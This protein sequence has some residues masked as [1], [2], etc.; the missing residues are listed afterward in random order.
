MRVPLNCLIVVTELS[1]IHCFRT[2]FNTESVH[3]F[4]NFIGRLV[5][6]WWLPGRE[7]RDFDKVPF[8]D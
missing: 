3:S 8:I 6:Q 1:S 5:G 7:H 4:I 2:T